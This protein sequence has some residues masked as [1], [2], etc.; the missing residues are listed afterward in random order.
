MST[1]IT[2]AGP[3]VRGVAAMIDMTA[4]LFVRM[5]IAAI[6]SVAFMN[7]ATLNFYA[8]F[9]EEFGSET[10]KNTPEHMGFLF[11]HALFTYWIIFFIVLIL[12]GAAY[13]SFFNSSSWKATPGKRLMNIMILDE[14]GKK[15]KISVALLHY[16]FSALPFAFVLYLCFY[17][18]TYHVNTIQ[19]ITENKV[20]L[21]IGLLIAI[22]M[23]AQIFNKKRAAVYD[24]ICRVELVKNLKKKKKK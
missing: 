17:Q 7:Q 8:E 10:I 12:A 18:I 9:K 16:F 22:C 15:I 19:A 23:Q 3:F 14:D 24:M 6:A 21:C 11:H 1:K 4:L 20:N 13:H 2:Y 5:F